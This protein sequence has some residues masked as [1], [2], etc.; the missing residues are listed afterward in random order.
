MKIFRCAFVNDLWML[1]EGIAEGHI[2]IINLD[3]F[4]LG[5][6]GKIGLTTMKKFLTY[7]QVIN[8][9]KFN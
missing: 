9:V 5:H 6:L 1:E 7:T 4:V 8:I 2:L 3:G